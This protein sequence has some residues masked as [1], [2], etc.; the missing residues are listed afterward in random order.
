MKKTILS[1]VAVM[2]LAATVYG[3]SVFI[4]NTVGGGLVN[5][6][7]TE[8]ISCT[9]WGGPVGGSLSEV[10][11]LTGG[12]LLNVG[13]GMVYDL[14]G[15]AYAIPGVAANANATLQMQFWLGNFNSYSAAANAAQLVGDSGPYTNPTGG[16]GVPATIPSSAMA[17]MPNITLAIVPEPS[18]LALC[19]LGLASLLVFRRR[20]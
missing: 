4:D 18:T 5:N 2:G 11:T 3:Q 14:S 16:G 1:A 7:G 20:N 12:S 17:N 10:K 13:G 19:G 9:L 15:T 8:Q 6:A